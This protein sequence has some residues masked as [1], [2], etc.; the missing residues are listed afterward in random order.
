[1]TQS[2]HSLRS[3]HNHFHDC[4]DNIYPLFCVPW[5]L[6]SVHHFCRDTMDPA[7]LEKPKRWSAKFLGLY[8]CALLAESVMQL[9]LLRDSS[10]SQKPLLSLADSA[11]F[12]LQS[13]SGC[14]AMCGCACHLGHS[15]VKV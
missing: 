13:V 15:C 8:M 5:M 4:R 3:L 7:F 12:H 9:C 6:S 14:R 11:A 2:A 1:M 10:S